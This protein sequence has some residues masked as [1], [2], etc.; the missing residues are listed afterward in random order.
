MRCGRRRCDVSFVH[1][2]LPIRL[3]LC[4]CR[5]CAGG[6]GVLKLLAKRRTML[7]GEVNLAF[8]TWLTTLGRYR[9]GVIVRSLLGLMLVILVWDRTLG[10][11]WLSWDSIV[12]RLGWT[13]TTLCL[14][15][16]GVGRSAVVGLVGLSV[17]VGL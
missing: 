10:I 5:V 13:E 17:G 9:I 4:S 7:V 6:R 1:S 3:M 14:F 2:I 16:E 11:V 8:C 12:P 15:Q